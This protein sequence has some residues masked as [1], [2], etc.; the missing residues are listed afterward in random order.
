M[1]AII[2]ALAV[3]VAL[4]GDDV[5]EETVATAAPTPEP[6]VVPTPSPEPAETG[7]G[8]ADESQAAPDA[9]A[10]EAD[11]VTGDD[12]AST[13]EAV[14]NTEAATGGAL[15]DSASC[16]PTF[17]G[18]VDRKSYA[19]DVSAPLA[20]PTPAPAPAAVSA[21]P[22]TAPAPTPTAAPEPQAEPTPEKKT[23]KAEPDPAPEDE[24]ES[25]DVADADAGADDGGGGGGGPTAEQWAALRA[26]ESGGNYQILSPGGLYRGAYQFSVPTWDSV[27]AAAYPSLVG[28]DPAQ[29]SPGDQDAMAYALYAMR[30]ASPWPHCGRH[31][32]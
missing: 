32:S 25:E 5:V 8:Q 9:D 18:A 27:A 19:A 21:D 7:V 12:V 3:M 23:K 14:A 24:A 29:A 11:G 28:V 22:T 30:G 1:L 26:C 10:P 16:V 13:G 17:V 15:V 6:T 20:A 4:E 2:A 31:L